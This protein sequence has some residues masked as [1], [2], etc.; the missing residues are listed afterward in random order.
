MSQFE[1]EF[2]EKRRS[3]F[4]RLLRWLLPSNC[5]ESPLNWK[6]TKLA[7]L[8]ISFIATA[9]T[10]TAVTVGV[11]SSKSGAGSASRGIQ[12][13]SI[14]PMPSQQPAPQVK[15]SSPQPVVSKSSTDANLP[16]YSRTV[17]SGQK[18][19]DKK[20][21]VED[22]DTVP[23]HPKLTA[24]LATNP[25]FN[26]GWFENGGKTVVINYIGAYR[27]T[28][29]E[30]GESFGSKYLMEAFD[31]T[32]DIVS[33]KM[34]LREADKLL[35]ALSLDMVAK[36]AGRYTAA[37]VQ[38]MVEEEKKKQNVTKN[39]N[40]FFSGHTAADQDLEFMVMLRR[41]A[42]SEGLS[43]RLSDAT[44]ERDTADKLPGDFLLPGGTADRYKMI[45][46]RMSPSDW[47]KFQMEISFA[48]IEKN[49]DLGKR[50]YS[51]LRNPGDIK[52][53]QERIKK[54]LP[55]IADQIL[56]S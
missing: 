24:L 49:V 31:H 36:V 33:A 12:V 47:E 17:D 29:R 10:A 16:P 14:V 55:T 37:E 22:P 15:V 45:L 25:C 32:S 56:T 54:F 19:G 43:V 35:E 41:T 18:C 48:E 3:G 39:E 8:A 27:G 40:P 51:Y 20:V 52:L 23:D 53:A 7:M 28:A 6:R 50:A 44:R 34:D 42:S 46:A 2:F 11:G 9:G 4:W 21:E 13:A 1:Q 5:W 30:F 26:F 38:R